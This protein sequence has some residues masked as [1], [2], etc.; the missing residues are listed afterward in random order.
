MTLT[1][2]GGI[3]NVRHKS[4][5]EAL[6]Y[7]GYGKNEVNMT[8]L[9]YYRHERIVEDIVEFG[10]NLLLTQQEAKIGQKYTTIL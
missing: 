9:T 1:L 7:K 2:W 8:M 10:Q 4:H 5:E 6:F 3:A